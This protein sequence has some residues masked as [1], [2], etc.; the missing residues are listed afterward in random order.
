[1]SKE[2]KILVITEGGRTEPKFFE[3]LIS[4]DG[5]NARIF[6]IEGNIYKLYK[7]M[8]EYHFLCDVK[9]A[10]AEL[11]IE[12]ADKEILKDTFTYTYLVFDCD[13]HH[14]DIPDVDKPL[15]TV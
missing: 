1:M 7:K 5:V 14:T 12:H 3:Q 4:I 10:L 6:S 15:E 9:D 11:K 13:A 2:T 8:Q